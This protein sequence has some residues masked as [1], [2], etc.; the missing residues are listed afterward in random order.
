MRYTYK[1]IRVNGKLRKVLTKI[2][3]QPVNLTP[4]AR[5]LVRNIGV[6]REDYLG[7]DPVRANCNQGL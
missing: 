3:R 4:F 1:L 5:R 7:E 6:G 2:E